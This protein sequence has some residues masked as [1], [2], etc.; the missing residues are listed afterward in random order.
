MKIYVIRHGQTTGDV[1]N[2]Y[3]GSYDDHLTAKGV[4][5]AQEL[6]E[7]M[8]SFGIE[9]IY[10]SPYIRAQETAKILQDLIGVE[11][12]TVENL[13]ER[14][15]NGILSGM[16]KQEAALKYP[17]LVEQLKDRFATIEGAEDYQKFKERVT[18]AFT[19]IENSGYEIA[20]VVTHG[21]PIRRIFAEILD[22]E[23]TMEIADCAWFEV[24]YKDGKATL[25][26]SEGIDK[27]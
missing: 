27:Q 18:N 2:R 16:I 21:G 15:Q 8:G 11:V 26:K 19:E 14:N 10:S 3:G 7:R 13:R 9:V 20:A 22:R 23:G 1:E 17:Q 6:A 5:Q 12:K 25:G 24:D 4:K